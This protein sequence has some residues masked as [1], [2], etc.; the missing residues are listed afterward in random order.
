VGSVVS[1][2]IGEVDELF[3]DK[4]KEREEITFNKL[5]IR[6]EPRL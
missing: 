2:L 5:P 6:E 3:S 4:D 1:D